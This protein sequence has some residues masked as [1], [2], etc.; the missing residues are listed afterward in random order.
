MAEFLNL[1]DPDGDPVY[2]KNDVIAIYT[3]TERVTVGSMHEPALRTSKRGQGLRT[4]VSQSSGG[5]TVRET[6]DEILD[7]IRL[8][9]ECE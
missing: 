2:I 3:S 9:T 1:T 6:Y 5:W 4:V 7:K 8:A